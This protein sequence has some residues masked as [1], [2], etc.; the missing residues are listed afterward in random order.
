M[1]IVI[2]L[3]AGIVFGFSGFGQC[4]PDTNITSPGY[5]PD[6]ATGLPHAIVG[7]PYSTVVQ[8]LV[9]ATYTT[10]NLDSVVL[11]SVTGLPAGF[12]YSYSF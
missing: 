4:V 8:V 2:T 6:S 3:L 9:P 11:G 10:Y 5:S 1:K 7:V 12:S